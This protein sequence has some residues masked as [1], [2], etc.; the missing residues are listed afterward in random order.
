PISLVKEYTAHFVGMSRVAEHLVATE[1]RKIDGY[2]PGSRIDMMEL[3]STR[4]LV[5]FWEVAEAAQD[6]E[7]IID[8]GFEE[9][10]DTK[11]KRGRSG[12]NSNNEN[13]KTGKK[14]SFSDKHDLFVFDSS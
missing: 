3:I 13:N 8:R 10:N 2:K 6:I 1:E 5:T 11:R 9:N 14:V 4:K 12:E 7:N